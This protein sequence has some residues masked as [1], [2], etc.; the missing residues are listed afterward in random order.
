M[1]QIKGRV[2]RSWLFEGSFSAK[3]MDSRGN[4]FSAASAEAA[5]DW[6]DKDWPSFSSTIEFAKPNDTEGF[7]LLA[8]D[9]IAGTLSN[10]FSVSIPVKFSYESGL[11]SNSKFVYGQCGYDPKDDPI[12]GDCG[13]DCDTADWKI[14]KN[15]KYGYSF[16]YDPTFTLAINC[17]NSNCVSEEQG[18]DVV[19]LQGNLSE[20]GWPM[21]T[22]SHH[23][24]EYYNP[25]TDIP[26]S[27]WIMEK[28][29]WIRDCSPPE[30]N[31]YF[32]DKDGKMFGGENIYFPRSPQAYSRREI[33]YMRNNKLFQIIMLDVDESQARQFYDTWLSTFRPDGE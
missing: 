28:F 26:A 20:V 12:L 23:P 32:K 30:E 9:N 29:P 17:K 22:I 16:R 8:P 3:L 14:Y 24:N 33:Y 27:E 21:I 15:K 19:M 31:I 25:P 10:P 5:E 2:K 6:P 4:V 1:A 11:G 7:L 18:G 13:K